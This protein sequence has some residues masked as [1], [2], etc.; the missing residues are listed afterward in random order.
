[1]DPGSTLQQSP[2]G[3]LRLFPC[4]LST[5]SSAFQ[6][7]DESQHAFSASSRPTLH[8]ALPAIEKLYAEWEKASTKLRY[9]PFKDAL[10]TAMEKFNEYYKR[11]SASDAHIICMGM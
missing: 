1:V 7:A 3:E 11:T 6:Y 9:E 5:L 2:S 8:N 10:N 4:P